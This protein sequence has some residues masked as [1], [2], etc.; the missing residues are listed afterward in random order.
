[1]KVHA[2][3]LNL[4]ADDSMERVSQY[5][6]PEDS[7]DRILTIE[8][9]LTSTPDE[10]QCENIDAQYMREIPSNGCGKID[11]SYEEAS[12]LDAQQE[13]ES[14]DIADT[15]AMTISPGK[16]K[17]EIDTQ[18]VQSVPSGENLDLSDANNF[19][20]EEEVDRLNEKAHSLDSADNSTLSYGGKSEGDDEPGNAG[21]E[22]SLAEGS[23]TQMTE[24]YECIKPELITTSPVVSTKG[25]LFPE[26]NANY[27][28]GESRF[29]GS[30]DQKQR[31]SEVFRQYRERIGD[32]SEIEDESGLTDRC[33]GS[34]I[35]GIVNDSLD[36]ANGQSLDKSHGNH[37]N[38]PPPAISSD[39]PVCDSNASFTPDKINDSAGKEATYIEV[40]DSACSPLN[41]TSSNGKGVA[42][43]HAPN[44]TAS[45]YDRVSFETS[46]ERKDSHEELQTF[47]ELERNLQYNLSLQEDAQKGSHARSALRR[48]AIGLIYGLAGDLEDVDNN[49]SGVSIEVIDAACS[50]LSLEEKDIDVVKQK[51]RRD[52]DRFSNLLPRARLSACHISRL[53]EER[54]IS[55]QPADSPGPPVVSCST[56]QDGQAVPVLEHMAV[57]EK[58]AGLREALQADRYNSPVEISRRSKGSLRRSG[59]LSSR[60]GGMEQEAGSKSL[61][62]H[63][64]LSE[65]EMKFYE[66]KPAQQ[67]TAS[68]GGIS[69]GTGGSSH[70]AESE[71]LFSDHQVT[72]SKRNSQN[73]LKFYGKAIAE[74]S[75][76]RIKFCRSFDL[77][78]QEDTTLPL[79]HDILIK[80]PCVSESDSD[81]QSNRSDQGMISCD[82]V[83]IASRHSGQFLQIAGSDHEEANDDDSEIA[84]K[85]QQSINHKSE[86]DES[87][88]DE[89][90]SVDSISS[91]ELG[92]I[93]ALSGSRLSSGNQHVSVCDLI[94]N[95]REDSANSD[96]SDSDDEVLMRS[97]KQLRRS[98]M[99]QP[100]FS[101]T[102]DDLAENSNHSM[103][104]QS[105][106]DPSR[107]EEDDA[108]NKTWESPTG[109]S[110][111]QIY[112]FFIHF[113]YSYAFF[114]ESY[115]ILIHLLI[116]YF[117]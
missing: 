47:R 92:V 50:P 6:V 85:D 8:D 2:T 39:V 113:H 11:D 5:F 62:S 116:S 45:D 44:S 42:S 72:D 38:T 13:G 104:Y 28:D 81:L 87:E 33:N 105:T 54:V 14:N 34:D 9:S 36:E 40:V 51:T 10:K 24:P 12:V 65:A 60:S 31:S 96:Q 78:I 109:S 19:V 15:L 23:Y 58:A 114:T 4:A 100:R 82:D 22:Q 103:K 70:Y 18:N 75:E 59:H 95:D 20:E 88:N 79:D 32:D 7:E 63:S 64:N 112:T 74:Q 110:F 57:Y 76:D 53:K 107:M 117:Q 46:A 90:S 52:N 48:S 55:D 1:M 26:V 98:I 93:S 71:S 102:F 94:D 3:S 73:G 111:L 35:V 77:D 43:L 37:V 21:I 108:F 41:I 66:Q 84:I 86:T 69:N 101:E 68:N 115:L 99:A 97:R 67:L 17:R 16:P 89:C 83:H 25:R 106:C 49:E 27:L 30:R 29:E 56:P 80:N 91:V 61:F